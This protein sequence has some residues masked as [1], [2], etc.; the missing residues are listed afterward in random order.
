MTEISSQVEPS[1]FEPVSTENH[2]VFIRSRTKSRPENGTG[3]GY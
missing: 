1:R 2:S 3:T